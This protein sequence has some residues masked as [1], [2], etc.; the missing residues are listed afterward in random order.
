MT[1][2][3]K[4]T[5]PSTLGA[6]HNPLQGAMLDDPRPFY[7]R[8]RAQEPVFWSETYGMW[9]VTRHDDVQA[10]A[11]DHVRFSSHDSISVAP[12][13]PPPALLEILMQGFPVLPSLVDG[14]PPLHT[15]SR[16]LVSKALSLRRLAVFEPILRELAHSLIDRF[17]AAGRVE[18]VSG[19]AI[20]LPGNFIVDLV[21]LPREDLEQVD[22][23][24]SNSA[25]VFAGRADSFEALLDKARGFVAF[26]HYL[27]A[28]IRERQ[29]S[30]RDD[31]LS[32]IVMGA[33]A[34]DEPLGMAELINIM[35][36]ILFA[37]YETT[38]GM[39]TAA[40]VELGRDPALFAALKA[41]PSGC[42]K[43]I[44]EALRTASPIHG[45]FRTALAD[46]E[47]G[48]V[49][50]R[51]GERV[52]IAYIS[53]NHDETRFADPLRFDPE[54]TTPH[55]AFG[56]GI[57]YCIGAPLARLEGRIAVEALT[58]RL[59]NL[60]LVPGQRFEY[61]PSATARRLEAVELEWG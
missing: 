58:A 22:R 26:Q 9:I 1:E 25:A 44:E 35:L 32:D 51:K 10:V 37:G 27:A 13:T 19:F 45:M 49:T 61:F 43:L 12:T 60:R 39:I 34:F 54:R 11:R 14:D 50:I 41:D 24:T 57:H 21:G 6:E 30:P 8:A 18:F 2:T 23:W 17:I 42:P 4:T 55:L 33:R 16:A 20:P 7:A 52:S 28:A 38:A 53:A 46:V 29:D 3:T 59:P 47:L 56:H 5:T 48:G 31:A 40:T 15:R 36:Q